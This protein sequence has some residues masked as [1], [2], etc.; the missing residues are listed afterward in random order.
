VCLAPEDALR[1]LEESVY[2]YQQ[3]RVFTQWEALANPGRY[4]VHYSI[5]WYILMYWFYYLTHISQAYRYTSTIFFD[6]IRWSTADGKKFTTTLEEAAA[7]VNSE[8]GWTVTNNTWY[9][10]SRI[11]LIAAVHLPS[12]VNTLCCVTCI[13]S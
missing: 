11:L 7:L 13:I 10:S 12:N 2:E 1:I 3:C 9:C 4:T 8:E 5:S 6:D